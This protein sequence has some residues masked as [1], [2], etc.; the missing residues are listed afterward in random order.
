MR[1]AACRYD[2]FVVVAPKGS[3]NA[4]FQPDTNLL[5]VEPAAGES[6][7]LFVRRTAWPRGEA[8]TFAGIAVS[9]LAVRRTPELCRRDA[10]DDMF[11]ATQPNGLT[12]S[13]SGPGPML[14]AQMRSLAE[15]ARNLSP[16]ARAVALQATVDLALAVL[17]LELGEER[18]ESGTRE[19]GLFAAVQ[20]FIDRNLGSP[21]LGPGRIAR[22][23]RC[24]RA[25]LYRIFARRGLTIAGY[26]REIRLQ[27]CRAAL[28]TRRL[29]G[30]QI[31]SVAW[32]F[33]F[34]NPV[35]FSRL[36][37]RRFGMT[38]TEAGLGEAGPPARG[39][40]GCRDQGAAAPAQVHDDAARE[41]VGGSSPRPAART[42]R[43]RL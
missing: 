39:R 29:R 42:T 16:P 11:V 2:E 10:A 41:G 40:Q 19:D 21:D 33:G 18:I 36:F 32:R 31:G 27:R 34:D 22:R 3:R 38:P 13:R 14:A 23:F 15:A 6:E 1:G 28:E 20:R 8:G 4:A 17:R 7:G 24:S 26:I 43:I 35:Y 5:R 12:P 25:H 30:E 37:R 9:S